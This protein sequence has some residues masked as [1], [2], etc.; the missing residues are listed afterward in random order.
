MFLLRNLKLRPDTS[1]I[2]K[3]FALSQAF[4]LKAFKKK[5]HKNNNLCQVWFSHNFAEIRWAS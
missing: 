4:D 1:Q 2:T 3:L 5:F